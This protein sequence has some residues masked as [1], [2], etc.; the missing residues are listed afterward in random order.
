MPP[1]MAPAA[2]GPVWMDPS[3]L[4]TQ[5]G[6]AFFWIAVVIVFIECGLL[7]PI[8]PG[9]TLLFAVGLFIATGQMGVNLGVALIGLSAAALLGNIVGY[10]I[11]RA[12]GPPLY[13]RDGRI[14][15]KRYF[16]QTTVFFERH[17]NKALV[18]GRFV[19]VV[20]T[21]VTV[22]AGV[23]RMERRRFFTW[24]A[25]GAV[26]WAVSVTLLGYLL[27]TSFPGLQ[28]KLELVILL[29]VAF[30][31]LPVLVEYLRHRRAA[32]QLR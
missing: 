8:L 32:G 3:Y 29:I 13:R 4:L 16:D 7:F 6:G 9:D 11:G 23:G 28:N 19:P 24:S 14:L 10:E 26:S 18:I 2:L 27:G 21:F 5:Y 12:V 22:V 15:K 20:R 17:G 25:V 1:L 30:S 31:L